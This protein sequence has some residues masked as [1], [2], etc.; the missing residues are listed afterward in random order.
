MIPSSRRSDE[1]RSCSKKRSANSPPL[2]RARESR[3]SISGTGTSA[4]TRARSSAAIFFMVTGGGSPATLDPPALH[5]VAAGLASPQQR[6]LR[7]LEQLV[8]GART[9]EA[10]EAD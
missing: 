6:F 5:P 9:G 1:V 7:R 10:G 4:G 8:R 3:R 2:D